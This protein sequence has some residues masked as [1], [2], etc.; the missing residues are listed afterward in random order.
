MA[1]TIYLPDGTT[2]VI[3]GNPMDA[4]TRL[5]AERLGPDAERIIRKYT[6]DLQAQREA[7]GDEMRNYE[8]TMES[9]RDLLQ[10]TLDDL[11]SLLPD[12][13]NHKVAERVT[14]ICDNIHKNL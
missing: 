6:V 8:G 11:Q 9:Q 2:E 12:I 4:L 10:D 7:L 13:K 1:D 5:V 3:L 14:E